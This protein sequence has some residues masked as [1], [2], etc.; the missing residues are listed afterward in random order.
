MT[1]GEYVNKKR[2]QQALTVKELAERLDCSPTYIHDIEHD[3]R[4]P[5]SQSMLDRFVEVFDIKGDELIEMY[6]S[7][8]ESTGEVPRDIA[9]Y[10]QSIPYLRSFLRVA[11]ARGYTEDDW[12]EVFDLID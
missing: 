6:D 12:R 8:S 4:S 10:I 3:R 2:L 9:D 11:I 7:I 5:F 1:F